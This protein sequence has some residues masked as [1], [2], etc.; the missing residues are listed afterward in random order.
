MPRRRVVSIDE[1]YKRR[2][3]AWEHY[4][5]LRALAR[6]MVT[7]GWNGEG[8]AHALAARNCYGTPEIQIDGWLLDIPLETR[9][10]NERE[11]LSLFRIAD[12]ELLCPWLW[13]EAGWMKFVRAFQ[14]LPDVIEDYYYRYEPMPADRLVLVA[15]SSKPKQ[16]A[17]ASATKKARVPY[18]VS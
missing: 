16:R 15:M 5:K 13:T 3:C 1:I 12:R 17:G 18:F 2:G 6:E 9:L 11:L 10:K 8:I 14:S 4:Y 7:V